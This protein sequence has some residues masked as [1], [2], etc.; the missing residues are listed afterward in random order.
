MRW[1]ERTRGADTSPFALDVLDI[2]AYC[3]YLQDTK[4]HVPATVN[5]RLQALRKFYDFSIARGWIPTNPASEVQLLGEVVSGRTR[6]LTS[7][8]VDRLL[9]AVRRAP[10]RRVDRDWAIV[11]VLI[12]T[13]LKLGELAELRMADVHLDADP[14]YLC[15]HNTPGEPG[16]TV[17]L[18]AEVCQALGDYLPSRQAA[19][20]VDRLFVNRDGNLLSTRSIQRLLRRYARAAGLDNLT[21][22]S[23]R[24]MYARK[25]YESCG[26]LKMV[27]DRLGHRHLATTIRYLDPDSLQEQQGDPSDLT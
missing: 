11:L 15:V 10:V 2:Q 27:S 16:R 21:T 5:R 24:Y 19:Q 26:D 3:S 23:L 18:E 4:N 14:P 7:A 8:D 1:S 9:A 25:V 20:G 13:G 6:S 12:G 17:P 22:Q